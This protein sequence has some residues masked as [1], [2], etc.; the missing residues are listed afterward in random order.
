MN[1]L[2]VHCPVLLIIAQFCP[3]DFKITIAVRLR[4][5]QQNTWYFESKAYFFFQNKVLDL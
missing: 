3:R 5:Q 1:S 4:G 2:L